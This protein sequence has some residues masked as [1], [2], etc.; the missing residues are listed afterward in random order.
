[1]I[2]ALGSRS[3]RPVLGEEVE[4]EETGEAVGSTTDSVGKKQSNKSS[5]RR[6]S[7]WQ[8]CSSADDSE[9]RGV[10]DE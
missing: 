9:I 10:D 1:M 8:Q 2:C 3:T 4:F 5:S 7:S 6:A